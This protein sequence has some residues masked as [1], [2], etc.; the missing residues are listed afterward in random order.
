M[1]LCV[2]CGIEYLFIYV[3]KAE[4]PITSH[5][6]DRWGWLA[7]RK[8]EPSSQWLGRDQPARNLGSRKAGWTTVRR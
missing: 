3:K 2:C 6:S 1:M 5:R 8:G 7:K 4:W